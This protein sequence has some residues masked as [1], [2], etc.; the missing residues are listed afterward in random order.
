[1]LGRLFKFLL[2]LLMLAGIGFVGFAYLSDLDPQQERVTE[3]VDL[4]LSG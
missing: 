2:V 3:P 4:E 1:M